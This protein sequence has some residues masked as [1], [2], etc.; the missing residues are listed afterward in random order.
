MK[1]LKASAPSWRSAFSTDDMLIQ[2]AYDAGINVRHLYP[3]SPPELMT[4]CL[5]VRY[6]RHLLPGQ[7]RADPRQALEAEQYPTRERRGHDQDLHE[8]G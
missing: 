6:C 5:G 3:S 7:L 2:V 8:L 1:H 4:V